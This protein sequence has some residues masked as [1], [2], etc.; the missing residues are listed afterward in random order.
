[1]SYLGEFFYEFKRE[2]VEQS[3]QDDGAVTTEA[4][5]NPMAPRPWEMIRH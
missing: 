3:V 5:H 2:V 4:K 1:V